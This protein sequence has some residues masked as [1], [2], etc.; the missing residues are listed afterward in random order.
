MPLPKPVPGMSGQELHKLAGSAREA[1]DLLKALAHQTRL[2][3][4]CILATEERT[5]GEIENLLGIQQAMVSQQLA[6]LR[7]EG[8]V[9]TRRQGRLVYYSIGNASVPVFLE[10]L[11]DLFPAAENN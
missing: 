6:R 9:N 11:F 4:L 7:L 3:I 2:L 1:S 8:L 5:V 10:S